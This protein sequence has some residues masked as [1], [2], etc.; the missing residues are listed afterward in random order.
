M[1]GGSSC[2]LDDP[3]MANKKTI[4][5]KWNSL[6]EIV[7]SKILDNVFCLN[8]KVTTIVDYNVT[9]DKNDILLKGKCKKCGRDVAR[10]VECEWFK[11]DYRQNKEEKII[12]RN[13]QAIGLF[14]TDMEKMVTFYRDIIGLETS[15]KKGEPNAEFKTGECS[16]IMYGRKDFEK[17]TSQKYSYP[18]GNNGTMEIAFEMKT[19]DAVDKEYKRLI[20]L[21]VKSIFPPT[22]ME[23]GQRTSYIVDPEGNL[24]EIGSF[25]K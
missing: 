3:S 19:Y 15:W 18:N 9:S 11:N 17:M 13:L 12:I 2:L 1:R 23:W 5:D 22:T 8:C 7:Q 21:G 10:L 6:G 14:V 16:L 4:T 24:I 25:N 20:D